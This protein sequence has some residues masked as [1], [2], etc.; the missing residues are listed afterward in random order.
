MYLEVRGVDKLLEFSQD[1]GGLVPID[2]PLIDVLREQHIKHKDFVRVIND[3]DRFAEEGVK[4]KMG[5]GGYDRG[6]I[7][8]DIEQEL[9]QMDADTAVEPP[10]LLG[11]LRG[12]LSAVGAPDHAIVRV[13]HPPDT[14]VLG[15]VD[16]I[17][18]VRK[19][20]RETIRLLNGLK[21][22]GG[23]DVERGTDNNAERTQTAAYGMEHL[24]IFAGRDVQCASIGG[25]QCTIQNLKE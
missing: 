22:I 16:D 18:P 20:V 12:F 2:C 13:R 14:R 7:S 17:V 3:A 6:P 1:L 10:A 19:H 9:V 15:R 25:N 24:G 5:D 21:T 23:F 8:A 4:H 11:R